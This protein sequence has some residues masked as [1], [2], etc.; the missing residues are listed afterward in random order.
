MTF[1]L[2]LG[3]QGSKNCKYLISWLV[4]DVL[5]IL[6]LLDLKEAARTSVLSKRWRHLWSILLDYYDFDVSGTWWW[7][8]MMDRQQQKDQ[9]CKFVD[10]VNQV[11][12]A[13]RATNIDRFRVYIPLVLSNRDDVH[14]WVDFAMGKSVK[15]LELDLSNR[16]GMLWSACLVRFISPLCSVS[17][18]AYIGLPQLGSSLHK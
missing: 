12:S 4:D 16:A 9:L 17:I 11:V 7:Q 18:W 14:T 8:G 2:I 6:S 3:N 10:Y 13:S 1:L 15:E 5:F